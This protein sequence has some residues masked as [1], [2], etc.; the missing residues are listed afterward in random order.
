MELK[1]HFIPSQVEKQSWNGNTK[2]NLTG[3]SHLKIKSPGVDHL[4]LQVP[5]GETYEIEITLRIV[6]VYNS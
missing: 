5:Q 1:E 3:T 4:D 2:F 6:K